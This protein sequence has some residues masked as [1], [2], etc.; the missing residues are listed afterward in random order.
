MTKHILAM[1]LKQNAHEEILLFRDVNDG[2]VHYSI[3][4]VTDHAISR[5]RRSASSLSRASPAM[6][7]RRQQSGFR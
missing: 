7:Q 1:M 6:R 2:I 4:D 3:I 5:A